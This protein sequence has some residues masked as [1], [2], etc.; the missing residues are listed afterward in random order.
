[1]KGEGANVTGA[2]VSLL[3]L[4]LVDSINPS[5]LLVTLYLLRR[6]NP[7]R[8]VSA[9]MVGV[10]VSYLAIGIMLVLGIDALLTKFSNALS[11]P[12]A[13]GAQ[14]VIGLAMLLYSLRS[15]RDGSEDVSRR[16]DS[17]AGLAGLFL[18]GVIVTVVELTTAAPY[19][20]ATGLLAYWQWPLYQWLPALVLYNLIFVSQPFGLLAIS[21]LMEARLHHGR[22]EGIKRRLERMGEGAAMWIIGIVGLYLLF[23]ALVYFDFFGLVEINLPEGVNSSLESLWRG[24]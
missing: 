13:S 1:M 12:A 17:A 15:K 3:G 5:A 18:L 2:L 7:V 20:V 11:G 8:T 9:Y 19:L 22:I 4:A 6:P 16:V 21:R 23:D 14:A 10:F 24:R